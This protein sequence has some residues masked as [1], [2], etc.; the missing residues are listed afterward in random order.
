MAKQHTYKGKDITVTWDHTRCIHAA[1]CIVKLREVFDPRE[2]LWVQPDNAE[3]QLVAHTVRDCPTGA[4]K[5][6][7][8]ESVQAEKP[9]GVNTVMIRPHGPLYIRGDLKINVQDGEESETRVALCRCGQ[10]KNKPF[11]DNSHFEAGFRDRGQIPVSERATAR[12]ELAGALVIELTPSGPL[13][14]HGPHDIIGTDQNVTSRMESSLCRCGRSQ[15]KPF[16]D[17]SHKQGF[18]D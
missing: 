6:V 8:T 5:Y 12:V 7:P 4:L 18:P 13:K 2:K 9:D 17:G 11:C 3:P 1:E 10:S 14:L 15:N 16:C